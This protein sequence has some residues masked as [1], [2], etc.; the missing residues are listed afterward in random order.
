[1]SAA[2]SCVLWG[3]ALGGLTTLL[4]IGLHALGMP[5]GLAVVTAI[6]SVGVGL[7]IGGEA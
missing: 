4:A 7:W 5:E 2:A 3:A 1:M 6:A